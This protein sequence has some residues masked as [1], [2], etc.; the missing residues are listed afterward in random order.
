MRPLRAGERVGRFEVV[1][2]LGQG[3]TGAVYEARAGGETVALKLLLPG[4]AS[5]PE[6][7]ARARREGRALAALDHPGIV[8]VVEAGEVEGEPFIA[9]EYLPGGTLASRA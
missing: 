6:L 5:S 4:L 3:G 1:R 2:L 9:L 7:M 8:R